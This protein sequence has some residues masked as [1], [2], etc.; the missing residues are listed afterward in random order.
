MNEYIYLLIYINIYYIIYY[1]ILYYIYI[2]IHF[3]WRRAQQ[4]TPVFLNGE[5]PWR[6]NPAGHSSWDSKGLDT[7]EAIQHATTDLCFGISLRLLSEKVSWKSQTINFGIYF[8]NICDVFTLHRYGIGIC[9]GM[10]G[11]LCW[12]SLQIRRGRILPSGT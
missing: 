8:G 7:T 6:R 2:F 5:S 12:N 4:P 11:S 10:Y 9:A 1:Y 3:P